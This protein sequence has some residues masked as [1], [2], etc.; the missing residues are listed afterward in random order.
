MSSLDIHLKKEKLYLN[1]QETNPLDLADS[2][3]EI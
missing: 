2:L 3:V 1:E